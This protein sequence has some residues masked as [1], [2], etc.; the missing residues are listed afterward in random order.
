MKFK[1]IEELRIDNDIEQKEIC[2]YLKIKQ[3]QYSRYENG[4]TEPKIG[5]I[6]KIADF[7]NVST[8]YLLGRTDIMKPYPRVSSKKPR[9]GRV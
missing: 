6:I 3:P 7:Y 1:R 8:D 9:S 2:D 4:I 5:I